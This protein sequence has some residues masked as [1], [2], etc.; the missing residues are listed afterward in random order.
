MLSQGHMGA[1]LHHSTGQVCPRF[2]SSGSL[3]QWKW[4]HFVMVEAVILFKLIPTSILDIY[5]VVES[6]VCCLKGIWVYLY[7]NPLARL[8]PNLWL[9]G[10]GLL[11]EW[12]RC[13]YVMVEATIHLTPLSTS[14]LNIFKVFKSVVCC[15][16][17]IWVDP[18]TI[19]PAK[20]AP[21]LGLS[22]TTSCLWL[23]SFNSNCSPYQIQSVWR[24]LY[25]FNMH[26]V[27]VAALHQYWP[28]PIVNYDLIIWV[29]WGVKMIYDWGFRP[30]QTA[31]HIHIRSLQSVWSF[32]MLSQG[33]VGAPLHHSTGQVGPR[34]GASG[35]LVEWKW[36]HYVMCK[37]DIHLRP[38]CTSV[39]YIY[40]VFE[41]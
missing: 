28:I 40:K 9:L 12:K 21:D 25:S 29:T 1:S 22:F 2:G 8:A 33:H 26:T 3:V 6:M 7:T 38:H 27:P 20:L 16:K 24:H 4:C 11:V 36:C 10:C 37:A 31:S 32:T 13:H 15:L 14:I 23:P 19:P 35:L 30:I 39:L 34:F 17:G 41:L 5:K 18:Y